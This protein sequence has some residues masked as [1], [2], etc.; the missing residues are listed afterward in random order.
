MIGTQDLPNIADADLTAAGVTVSAVPG[1]AFA[2]TVATLT[3]AD[4]GGTP[5][6]Y[7]ATI[8]WG[9]GTPPD[10]GAVTAQGGGFAVSGSNTYT[11]AANTI[12]IQV[13]DTGGSTATATTTITDA[14]LA[15]AQPADITATA[16][17][18]KGAAANYALPAVT[19]DES[20]TVAPACAPAPGSTFPVGAT[21]VTCSAS[22]S[23]DSNSPVTTSF[24]VTVAFV[25][26]CNRTITSGVSSGQ[27]SVASGET[28]CIYGGAVPG[29]YSSGPAGSWR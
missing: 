14:D 12:T 8:D 19:D 11:T 15:I 5:A 7:T 27:L 2:G 24:T 10:Q 26:A 23:S 25:P 3:D 17:S 9:D 28:V 16:T 20:T 13:T 4:P 1:T 22:D 18:A 29:G 6:D 21:T